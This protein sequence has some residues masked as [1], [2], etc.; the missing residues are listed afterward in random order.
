MKR[1]FVTEKDED[2]CDAGL[3][4]DEYAAGRVS[5]VAGSRMTIVMA[6]C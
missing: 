2:S 3:H 4:G 5:I 6:L 1:A